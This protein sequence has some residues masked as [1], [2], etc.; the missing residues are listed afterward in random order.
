LKRKLKQL[1][2]LPVLV[3]IFSLAAAGGTVDKAAA[4]DQVTVR[5]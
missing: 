3:M 1:I 5:L 2:L 4:A